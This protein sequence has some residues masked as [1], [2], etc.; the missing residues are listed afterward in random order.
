MRDDEFKNLEKWIVRIEDRAR[1]FGL[2]IRAQNFTVCN[3]QKML[4]KEAQI[5]GYNLYSH[6]S[7]GKR[8]DKSRT[9]YS[10]R[11]H[12]LPYE[13]V[14]NTD[15]CDACLL[16]SNPLTYNILVAAH[17]YGH[18]DFYCNNLMYKDTEPKYIQMYLR[19]GG[20]RIDEYVR[21]PR[22]GLKHVET[23]IDAAHAVRM[24][25][26]SAGKSFL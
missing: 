8:F 1:E 15:P 18:N 14:I 16:D 25:I 12:F 9:L 20:R 11:Y 26:N 3:A 19:E 13:M 10:Y 7:F 24:T 17:V 6:W 21:N 23:L 5:G 2:K 4:E 22:I